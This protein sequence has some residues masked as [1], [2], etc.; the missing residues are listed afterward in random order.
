MQL[1]DFVDF[2]SAVPSLLLLYYASRH[3]IVKERYVSA[4]ESAFIGIDL[5]DPFAK[6][7]RR[8]TR[9]ILGTDLYCTF[10]EWEY[11]PTGYAIVSSEVAHTPH[12]VAMD[13]PQGLASSLERRMRLCEQQLGTAGK[14]LYEFR[15]IGQPYAGFVRGSVKLFYS[16]YKSR[17]F[18]L[19]GI[20]KTKLSTVNLI[21]VYP[22]AAWPVLAGYRLKKK[23]LLEGRRARYDL[24]VRLGITFAQRYSIEM[25]PT[26]DQLDAAVA[27]YIA[28]LFKSGKTCD[29]GEK[30]FEDTSLEILREGLIIQPV[31]SA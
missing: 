29:Y 6:H 22:G 16:L 19:C 31:K 14:S 15:P 8:S 2:C 12:I 26:H 17:N 20:Q 30:P 28:Y 18:Q 4:G 25:P 1:H 23:R 7:K 13:G 9:S 5:S 21:E 10:D 27:A 3:D 11:N 24:M